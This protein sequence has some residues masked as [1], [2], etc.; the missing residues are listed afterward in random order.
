V[1]HVREAEVL[2]EGESL[3]V[4]LADQAAAAVKE[5]VAASRSAAASDIV[6]VGVPSLTV[7]ERIHWRTEGGTWSKYDGDERELTL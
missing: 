6:Y 3:E 7:F 2:R 5:K 1:R 4:D